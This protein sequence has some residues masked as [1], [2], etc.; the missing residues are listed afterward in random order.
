MNSHAVLAHCKFEAYGARPSRHDGASEKINSM[1]NHIGQTLHRD[2]CSEL[3]GDA[4]R[5]MPFAMN[6]KRPI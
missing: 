5:R 3:R 4:V 6:Q 1:N 2:L